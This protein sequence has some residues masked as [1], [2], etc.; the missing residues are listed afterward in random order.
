MRRVRSPAIAMALA[1]FL[2]GCGDGGAREPGAVPVRTQ[3]IEPS[4]ISL[5]VIAPC[6]LEGS[7]EAVLSVSVPAAVAGVF[8]TEGDHVREGDLLVS[9]ETD[10]MHEAEVAAAAAMF[11]AAAAAADYQRTRL[12]RTAA[13][14]E[15]G[16]VPL[17]ALE[18]A[19]ADERSASASAGLARAG[20]SR[21][22]SE[23]STGL[24]RAP[25]DGTVSRVW[26]RVGNPAAGSLVAL[27][28]GGVLEAE[29]LLAPSRLGDLEPGLP[30]VLETPVFPGELFAGSISSVSPSADPLSGLV[31]AR[32]QF[33]DPSG[34]L[35]PGMGCTAIVALH[36][37]SD[38]IVVPQSALER[39]PSGEWRAA[40]V[41]NG[42]A[43]FREV[44]LGIRN[45]F[46]WQVLCGL[47][48]GDTIVT[49]GINRIADGSLVREAGR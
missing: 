42:I 20:Y 9:L 48:A 45:G 7:D 25:F 38:A 35:R 27:A 15:S 26:A 22:V 24:V 41:E 34:R 30:V 21:A 5:I 16:A 49:T 17:S 29:L 2:A 39:A 10:G 1:F 40:V 6:R 33:V 28:G 3:V 47:S 44:T 23:A 37:V 32:A 18:Q 31:S 4:P 36:T 8:V 14:F 13:L 11:S 19:M 46:S 12:D 43:R